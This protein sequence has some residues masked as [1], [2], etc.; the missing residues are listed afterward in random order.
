MV[1]LEFCLIKKP[2]I[3]P[4]SKESKIPIACCT[5]DPSYRAT[6]I[7]YFYLFTLFF[8]SKLPELEERVA[9]AGLIVLALSEGAPP[10]CN[11]GEESQ[12]LLDFRPRQ[13]NPVRRRGKPVCMSPIPEATVMTELVPAILLAVA[14]I[15]Q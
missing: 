3:S 12:G 10:H 2:Q 15:S 9:M 13:L 6:K 7:C 5:F 11:F 1:Y 4:T 14:V 8:P